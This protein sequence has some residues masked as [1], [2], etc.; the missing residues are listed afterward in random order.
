MRAHL[1]IEALRGLVI[2]EAR[3]ET[4]C[5]RERHD[6]ISRVGRKVQ[7]LEEI[8]HWQLVTLVKV[9]EE[10][11]QLAVG[12]LFQVRDGWFH[13]G[14]RLLQRLGVCDVGST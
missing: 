13:A 7:L 6:A 12:F 10:D 3:V 4:A 11:T 5:V 14:H 8:I 1:F 9:H 2:F